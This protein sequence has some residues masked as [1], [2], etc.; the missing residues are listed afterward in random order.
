VPKNFLVRA[1]SLSDP[2]GPLPEEETTTTQ[3]D[4]KAQN[5]T[6]ST[7][8]TLF[9]EQSTTPQDETTVL[10]QSE[11]RQPLSKTQALESEGVTE[12]ESIRRSLKGEFVPQTEEDIMS[13]RQ[14]ADANDDS[15]LQIASRSILQLG[16]TTL[17]SVTP[18]TT[19]T[20]S[21]LPPTGLKGSGSI[22]ETPPKRLKTSLISD[23]DD[24]GSEGEDNAETLEDLKLRIM[25][26]FRVW[27]IDAETIAKI[28]AQAELIEEENKVKWKCSCGKKVTCHKEL[29]RRRRR[30]QPVK[31]HLQKKCPI[32]QKM[33]KPIS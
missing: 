21:T 2:A 6:V 30:I 4:P 24:S 5:T 1:I 20:S 19:L 3:S 23:K 13:D 7:A 26:Y 11:L 22:Q 27:N 10:R 8:P 18:R 14:K 16:N 31:E 12:L 15:R 17:E 28:S 32:I 29:Q 25:T 33:Q 9:Q